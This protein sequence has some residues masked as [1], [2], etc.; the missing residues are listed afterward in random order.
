MQLDGLLRELEIVES[1]KHDQLCGRDGA[2]QPLAQL[3]PAHKRHLDVGQD[4]IRAQPAR[5]F[6]G[7]YAVQGG[8]H[9]G[10][11]DFFP[12]DFLEDSLQDFLFVIRYQN[13]IQIHS[14]P[15]SGPAETAPP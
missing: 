6:E 10:E 14:S 13:A 1:G 11:P 15:V 2:A 8:T 9:D 7:V 12:L 4:E 3:Q 5:L